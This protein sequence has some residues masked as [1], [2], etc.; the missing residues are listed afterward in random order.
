LEEYVILAEK[1]DV[2]VQTFKQIAE[3]HE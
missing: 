2:E 1:I 3:A